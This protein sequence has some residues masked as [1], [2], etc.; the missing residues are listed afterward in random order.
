MQLTFEIF[1]QKSG[2]AG[3]KLLRTADLKEISA[4]NK[5]STK[6]KKKRKIMPKSDESEEYQ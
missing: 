2:S 1:I 4:D 3:I 6:R 5:R